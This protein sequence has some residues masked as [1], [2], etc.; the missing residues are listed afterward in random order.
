M[1]KPSSLVKP[2]FLL[3]ICGREALVQRVGMGGSGLGKDCLTMTQE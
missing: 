1:K 2:V 3:A